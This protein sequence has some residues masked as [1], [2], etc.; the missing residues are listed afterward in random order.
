MITYPKF[1]KGNKFFAKA[2]NDV[3][4]FARRHGVNPASR[5]GWSES[6]DGW[7]PPDWQ[8]PPEAPRQWQL[9]RSADE[10]G[11]PIGQIR[12]GTLSG[13]G[14]SGYPL[15]WVGD[16]WN[17]IEIADGA[18]WLRI[19]FEPISE[20]R[21]YALSPSSESSI[22]VIIGGEDGEASLVFTALEDAPPEDTAPAINIST[23]A[24]TQNGVYHARIGSLA[25]DLPTNDYIGPL[26]V[27]YC[28]PTTV[29]VYQLT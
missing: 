19:E 4:S 16:E 6:A 12:S 14:M 13:L 7:I 17:D 8:P 28:P 20:E 23:G 27:S 18:V 3:V 1:S 5:R 2:L 10:D 22:Y 25:T 11:E 26:G 21:T 9:Q 24:V 15:E 29:V